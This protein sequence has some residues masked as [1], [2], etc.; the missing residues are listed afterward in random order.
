MTV[1]GRRAQRY[2]LAGLLLLALVV[3]AGGAALAGEVRLEVRRETGFGRLV[4][5]AEPL[6]ESTVDVKSTILIAHFAQPVEVDLSSL[7]E[8]LPDYVSIARRDPDGKGFRVALKQAFKVNSIPA[9]NRLVIDI[10]G[11]SWNGPPPGLPR[12]IVEEL[13]AEAAAARKQAEELARRDA[14]DMRPL[15]LEVFHANHPTFSRIQFDWNRYVGAQFTRRGNEVTVAFDGVAKTALAPLTV[16]PPKGLVSI[17]Q[18]VADR[19]LRIIMMIDSGIGVRAFREGNKYVVDLTR[20]EQSSLSEIEKKLRAAAGHEPSGKAGSEEINLAAE[21]PDAQA[22]AAG[23]PPLRPQRRPHQATPAKPHTGEE[24]KRDADRALAPSASMAPPAPAVAAEPPAA[25][26]EAKA[27]AA[28]AAKAPEPIS[29]PPEPHPDAPAQPSPTA[30]A[31][32]ADS[33]PAEA[34]APVA[35]PTEAEAPVQEEPQPRLH[36]AAAPPQTQPAAAPAAEPQPAEAPA[37][38]IEAQA[39]VAMPAEAEARAQEEPQP[40]PRPQAA[41]PVMASPSP[42]AGPPATAGPVDAIQVARTDNSVQL[43]FPFNKEAVAAAIFQRGRRLW[44]LIDDPRPVDIAA[45][46]AQLGGVVNDAKRSETAGG[47]IFEFQLSGPWL[48]SVSKRDVNWSVSIGDLVTG[49]SEAVEMTRRT[50]DKGQP[51]VL[52]ALQPS[53]RLHFIR[54]T[55][56]GDDLAVVTATAPARHVRN[57]REFV[58]FQ[59]FNTIHGVVVRPL[60]DDVSVQLEP[61]GV[62]IARVGGL[63]LSGQAMGKAAAGASGGGAVTPAAGSRSGEGGEGNRRTAARKLVFRDD[64]DGSMK[65]FVQRTLKLERQAANFKGRVHKDSLLQLAHHWLAHGFGPESAGILELLRSEHEEVEQDP[66]F[67]LM[68]GMSQVLLDRPKLAMRSLENGQ[69]EDNPHA[70]LWRGMAAY[71]L[72][73]YERA[74]LEFKRGASAINDY[75]VEQQ[76]AFR[77][78]AAEAALERNVLDEAGAE[79]DKLPDA[80]ATAVQQATARFLEGRLMERQ[81]RPQEAIRMYSDVI[82][83][84]IEPA[85]SRAAYHLVDLRLRVGEI[86]PSEAIDTLERLSIA[87]RGDDT[88]LMALSRLADLYVEESRYEDAFNLMETALR[89][90]PEKPMALALQDRMKQQFRDLFLNGKADNIPPI[91]ALALFYDHKQLTPPGRLG[92][93]MIRLLTDR[94][95]AVD[96]LDKASEL[97]EHQVSRRLKGAGRAQVAI[98]LA[99]IQLMQHQPKKALDTLYKTSQPNLPAQVKQARKILEA[100]AFADLGRS[101]AVLELLGDDSSEEGEQIKSLAL[102]NAQSWGAAGEQYEKALKERWQDANELTPEE[103]NQVLRAAIAY[104]LGGDA[105]GAQRI[106]DKFAAKMAG[107]SDAAAFAVITDPLQAKGDVITKMA[108]DI[109]DIDTLEAFVKAFRQRFD[110][111]GGPQSTSA[112]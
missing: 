60:A 48:S 27:D 63:R 49:L 22:Q 104:T 28:V 44:V 107:G 68:H 93:E 7:A 46:K 74:Q 18:E 69:L 16:Q 78:A 109:A 31:P 34:L 105:L 108:R 102:W 52:V 110:K 53:G 35:K 33:P 81:N 20:P 83:F 64:T 65:E 25:P 26:H 100:R 41:A 10:L 3:V 13:A 92:D 84:D 54:D 36:A 56:S 66:V 87:W 111:T 103:R 6:P 61:D 4:L 73:D 50:T 97:L 11:T 42:A 71:Q 19:Q 12:D 37:P 21:P 51:E 77:L 80:G 86:K 29:A 96:L 59:V 76:A 24:T 30:A 67:K 40:Q 32:A 57:Y 79:L 106:R 94:L 23:P 88:E 45:L 75:T 70:S 62:H 112:F 58:D 9:G 85:A 91:K 2:G 8:K 89:A 101:G 47:Q 72:H 39:P 15:Q 43:R 99:M 95:V 98:R 1:T 90:Y 5:R 17:R 38:P 14:L 55:E 82:S